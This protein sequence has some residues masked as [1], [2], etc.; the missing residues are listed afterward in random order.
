MLSVGTGFTQARLIDRAGRSDHCRR[1]MQR[2]GAR[3]LAAR[4]HALATAG[5]LGTVAELG[6]TRAGDRLA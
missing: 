1:R 5:T 4:G 2:T 6:P 3:A